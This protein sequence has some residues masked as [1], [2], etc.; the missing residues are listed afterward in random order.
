MLMK[1]SNKNILIVQECDTETSL[2]ADWLVQCRQ[3]IFFKRCYEKRN[4]EPGM[5][6]GDDI[7]IRSLKKNISKE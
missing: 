2:P 3:P 6:T 1:I 4:F 7:I 5:A